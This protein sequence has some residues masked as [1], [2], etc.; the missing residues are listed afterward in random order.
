MKHMKT[1]DLEKAAAEVI[2]GKRRLTPEE[3]D[4]MVYE[5]LKRKDD[6]EEKLRQELKG[7]T[8]HFQTDDTPLIA[9]ERL[10]NKKFLPTRIETKTGTWEI[11]DGYK[12]DKTLVGN[13]A[14]KEHKFGPLDNS[15]YRIVLT[16]EEW[17]SLHDEIEPAFMLMCL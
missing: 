13:I 8:I 5:A 7:K 3:R 12:E 6:E 10:E 15:A 2:N 16:V 9:E 17:L 1:E 14:K 11:L 4:Q